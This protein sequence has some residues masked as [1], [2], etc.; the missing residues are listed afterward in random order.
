MIQTHE[1]Y[2]NPNNELI[3]HLNNNDNRGKARLFLMV[4]K[5]IDQL[6]FTPRYEN[7]I[8]LCLPMNFD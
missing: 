3:D 2:K 4:E 7:F 6:A 1:D 8:E 5:V